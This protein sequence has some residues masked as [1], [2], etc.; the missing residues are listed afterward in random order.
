MGGTKDQLEGIA[1]KENKFTD[2]PFLYEG[3][4]TANIPVI[5]AIQGHASGGG[6]LFGLY[7]DIVIVSKQGSYSASFM[8]YG[9]TP[10]MGA[11]YILKEKLGSNL[12]NEMM[13]SANSF[14]GDELKERGAAILFREQQEVLK[15]A[16]KIASALSKKPKYALQVLKQELSSRALDSLYQVLDKEV[17]MHEL[18][19]A[20]ESVKEKIKYYYHSEEN[21]SKA[22]EPD[23]SKI[24]KSNIVNAE[25]QINTQSKAQAERVTKKDELD[26]LLTQIENGSMK[27]EEALERTFILN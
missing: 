27:P 5:A 25:M 12:A 7:A 10:G 17:K 4:L 8:K 23:K 20:S 22:S 15:E 3:L 1:E 6:F 11:T 21:I 14:G 13:F 26:D 16:L 2:I 24:G 18:T 9:F 19:F